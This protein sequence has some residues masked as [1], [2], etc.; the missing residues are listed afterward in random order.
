M[1]NHPS[2]NCRW[3]QTTSTESRRDPSRSRKLSNTE[4]WNSMLPSYCLISKCLFLLTLV[5]F[6][7]SY[8]W[9]H[10]YVFCTRF[11]TIIQQVIFI[12]LFSLLFGSK[13]SIQYSVKPQKIKFYTKC[14]LLCAID[15]Y[16]LEILTNNQKKPDFC[17]NMTFIVMW[18]LKNIEFQ[19]FDWPILISSIPLD[20]ACVVIFIDLKMFNL[21]VDVSYIH[22]APCNYFIFI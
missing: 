5:P 18:K 2:Y 6:L 20:T 11:V 14:K 17:A 13:Y 21:V 9:E 10:Q 12:C 1:G 19:C 16:L 7:E 3:S 15:N 8:A 4:S 22:L